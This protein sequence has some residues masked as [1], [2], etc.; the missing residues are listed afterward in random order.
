MCHGSGSKLLGYRVRV[1]L[2]PERCPA[3]CDGGGR[4]VLV[5]EDLQDSSFDRRGRVAGEVRSVLKGGLD[6][7][8]GE[9]YRCE[10]LDPST[11]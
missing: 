8:L 3:S 11:P 6:L 2:Q 7:L 4:E 10:W 1:R 9:D 5:E